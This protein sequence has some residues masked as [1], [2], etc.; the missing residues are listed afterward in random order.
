M[1]RKINFA[2]R[3]AR[4]FQIERVSLRQIGRSRF[5]SERFRNAF[6]R[7]RVFRFR[8]LPRVFLDL[9][10]VN[11]LHKNVGLTTE[12]TELTEENFQKYSASVLC[13]LRGESYSSPAK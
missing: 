8:R 5:A 7:R 10:N 1:I 4:P 2:R 12:V 9:V 13:V 11:L 3:N 6:E